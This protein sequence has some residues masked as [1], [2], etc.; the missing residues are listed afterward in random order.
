MVRRILKNRFPKKPSPVKRFLAQEKRVL[1]I[2]GALIMLLTFGIKEVTRE[3]VKRQADALDLV[4]TK[5]D[6]NRHVDGLQD[7]LDQLE[8]RLIPDPS[9]PSGDPAYYLPNR[10]NAQLS[11]FRELLGPILENVGGEFDIYQERA[12]KLY[13]QWETI[14]GV[15]SHQPPQSTERLEYMEAANR[16]QAAILNSQE[17]TLLRLW[18][19]KASL[20]HEYEEMSLYFYALFFAGFVLN[21]LGIVA[22]VGA[23][24]G[25]SS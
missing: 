6:I 12:K 15:N 8:R 20:D 24:S 13:A 22:S 10:I 23:K 14:F 5:L 1:S 9:N 4:L 3:E 19:R 2:V 21:I 11:S 18:Y 16:L 25:E 7:S 17:E